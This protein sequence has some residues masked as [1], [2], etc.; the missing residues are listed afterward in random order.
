MLYGLISD[1]V[2]DG[3][4]GDRLHFALL[5]IEAFGLFACGIGWI[6]AERRAFGL[7][8]L[9]V[10]SG[11]MTIG[12]TMTELGLARM[13]GFPPDEPWRGTLPAPFLFVGLLACAASLLAPVASTYRLAVKAED[14]SSTNRVR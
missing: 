2:P 6:V 8:L 12:L 11:L 10:R 5:P 9:A 7:A 14:A 13:T 1:A 4:L 3:R